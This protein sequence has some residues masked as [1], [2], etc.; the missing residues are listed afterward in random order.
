MRGRDERLKRM[1]DLLSS[2][3]LVK[4]YAWEEAYI[5]TMK[6]L[7]DIELVP[8]FME[9]ILD[10]LVDSLYSSSSSMV[11]FQTYFVEQ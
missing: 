6:Q 5:K 3:R 8:V 2:V 7:R 10:G 1:S 11:S 4:M 9:N